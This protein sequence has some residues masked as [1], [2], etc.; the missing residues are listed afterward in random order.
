MAVV[1]CM[2]CNTSKQIVGNICYKA[3]IIAE[4]V[5]H[6]L[7]HWLELPCQQPVADG[8]SLAAHQCALPPASRYTHIHTYIYTV[9]NLNICIAADD[10][11]TS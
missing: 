9:K 5:T 6:L 4:T 7:F 11:Y 1:G 3:I 2:R 8:S 10:V